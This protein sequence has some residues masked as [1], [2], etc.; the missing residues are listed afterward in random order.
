MTKHPPDTP[1]IISPMPFYTR[2]GVSVSPLTCAHWA[3]MSTPDLPEPTTTTR[4]APDELLGVRVRHARV[5]HGVEHLPMEHFRSCFVGKFGVL[6]DAVPPNAE[7]QEIELVLLRKRA[8]NQDNNFVAPQSK[9]L[10][11]FLL[12]SLSIAV[13]LHWRPNL[14]NPCV[15]DYWVLAAPLTIPESPPTRRASR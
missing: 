10:G 3:T 14:T 13:G 2:N 4:F 12:L 7:D 8:R 6:G 1:S 9:R 5:L 15:N 11:N